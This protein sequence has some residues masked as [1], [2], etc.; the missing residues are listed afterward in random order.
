MYK[1]RTILVV[2]DDSIVRRTVL[3]QLKRL[4]YSGTAIVNGRDALSYVSDGNFDLVLMDVQMPI[5][6]G[7]EATRDIRDW[8]LKKTSK[9]RIPIVAMTANPNRK[10][11]YEVGMDDF[12]FKPYTL[13][14]LGKLIEKW[15]A[16]TLSA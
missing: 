10:Q 14:E 16:D 1:K 15:T 13:A 9:N 3:A 8:E 2:E 4:G 6:S 12:L 7:L 11:C 5:F